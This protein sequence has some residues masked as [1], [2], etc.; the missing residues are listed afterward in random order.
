MITVIMPVYIKDESTLQITRNAIYSLGECFLIIVDNGSQMGGGFLRDAA[1]LYIRNQSNLG[2]AKAVNQGLALAKTNLVAIVNNDTRISPNWQDV[3]K[4]VLITETVYSCHF[5][6]IN[7][8]EP[9]SFGNDIF[10]TGKERWCT[11]SFY[12]INTE[13]YKFYFDENF[14][15]SYCDWDYWHTVR[16]AGLKTAY[17]NKACYQHNHSFTQKQ[18]PNWEEINKKNK[19]Y[20]KKKWGDYAENLFAKEFPEQMRANYLDGF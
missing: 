12:V 2:Y 20:F 16:K 15:N 9:F 6:M 4:E 1:A 10:Y 5:K 3:A 8:D 13:K 19:E 14:F 11:T 18:L 17:T 7:Y